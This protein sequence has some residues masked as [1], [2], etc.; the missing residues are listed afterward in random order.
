MSSE[1]SSDAAP[2]PGFEK[3]RAAP[4]S[5]NIS[6]VEERTASEEI[7]TLFAQYRERFSRTDLPGIL[8]CFAT[9]A[10]LLKGMLQIAENFLF[11][12]SLLNR[13]HKEMIATYVSQQNACPY[14][15]D[16][17]AAL[18]ATQAGSPQMICALQNG[19]LNSEL[20]TQAELTLLKFAGKVNAASSAVNRADVDEAMSKGWTEAQVAEAVHIAALFAAFN[21]IANGFGLPSPYPQGLRD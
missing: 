10:A 11:G 9:N 14:C 3:R 21:R 15:A 19:D 18:L 13:R 2:L 6:L 12:E 8:L 7:R 17:H 5:S 1:L 16:S 20:L 4:G